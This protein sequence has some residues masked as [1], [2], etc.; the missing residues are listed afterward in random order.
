MPTSYTTNPPINDQK[1]EDVP[2]PSGCRPETV[3]AAICVLLLWPWIWVTRL[4]LQ[5]FWLVV[6]S[7][8]IGIGI[9]CGISGMRRGGRNSRILSGMC[10][11]ILLVV[12][13]GF[14]LLVRLL[15]LYYP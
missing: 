7:L 15:P 11:A 2:K 5:S 13:G 12:G 9:G 14:T 10:V 3:V 6:L 4:Q 1:P 8:I